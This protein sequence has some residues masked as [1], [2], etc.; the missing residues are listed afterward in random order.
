MIIEG[1][2]VSYAQGAIDWT[3]VVGQ[4][5]FVIIRGGYGANNIDARARYNCSECNRVGIP[6]GLYWFSYAYTEQMARLEGQYAADFANTYSLGWPIF[7]DFEY[8]SEDY[9]EQ[10]GVTVTTRL[11][12]AMANAFCESVEAEGFASGLYYN[13]DYNNRF[14][15]DSFFTQYP[16]RDKWVAK[17]SST[18]PDD[19]TIWQYG[20]SQAGEV[21][22]ISTQVDL[23][24]IDTD[25]P[26]PPPP[27]P[28]ESDK[29][30]IWF[31][32]RPY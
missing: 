23:D 28:T 30:P 21:P 4:K 26:T 2:D 1:I 10:H 22:G 17:W 3:R 9:A 14:S 31:Y 6:I 16:D 27:T 11:Y 13:P 15:I 20:L 29:M 24:R 7:W 18:P 25:K 32:L 5:Y 8:D 12:H 19:Y